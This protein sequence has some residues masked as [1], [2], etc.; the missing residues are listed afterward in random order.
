MPVLF[1]MKLVL[2]AAML[3]S[4]TTAWLQTSLARQLTVNDGLSQNY[5]YAIAQDHNDFM[6]FGTKDGLNRFD[7]YQFKVFKHATN[8]STTISDNEVIALHN[9]RKGRLWVG[10]SV[11]LNLYN[12]D[13]ESFYR[14]DDVKQKAEIKGT[15]INAITEDKSGNIWVHYGANLRQWNRKLKLLKTT[16]KPMVCK[17]G[18]SIRGLYL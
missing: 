8:D 4:P 5:I 9:D 1:K 2:I 6:W 12:P 13:T 7:G 15:H 3:I 17:V 18:S 14:F 10:T 16:T 11:G